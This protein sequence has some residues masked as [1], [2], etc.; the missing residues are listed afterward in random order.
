MTTYE[1]SFVC[2]GEGILKRSI[3]GC[4]SVKS[5]GETWRHP[6]QGARCVADIAKER[7]ARSSLE[8]QDAASVSDLL[9]CLFGNE[10]LNV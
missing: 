7:L 2:D 5:D 6:N 10:E 9:G 4:Q 1:F 8:R 3:T